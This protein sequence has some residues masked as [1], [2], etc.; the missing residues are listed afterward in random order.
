MSENNRSRR[1]TAQP[2]RLEDEQTDM[3]LHAQELLDIRRA[4]RMSLQPA[5][6]MSDADEEESESD[7]DEGEEE[8][9]EENEEKADDSNVSEKLRN[10]REKEEKEGW[11]NRHTPVIPLLSFLVLHLLL[12][13]PSIMIPHHYSTS[14]TFFLPPLSQILLI[15]LIYMPNSS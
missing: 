7:N 11:D 15:K 9:E 14:I 5:G 2:L 10:M 1:T 13:H 3:H 6:Y 4:L 12:R 8:E